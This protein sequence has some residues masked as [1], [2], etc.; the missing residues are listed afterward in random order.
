M[1]WLTEHISSSNLRF[2]GES[3]ESFSQLGGKVVTHHVA[4]CKRQR[5]VLFSG[6][7]PSFLYLGAAG[8]D[9]TAIGVEG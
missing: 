3:L 1:E 8:T 9:T 4:C 5:T 6:R 2:Y 7:K